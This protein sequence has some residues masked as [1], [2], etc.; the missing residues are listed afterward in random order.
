MGGIDAHQHFWRYSEKEYAW[1]DSRMAVLR[2]DFLPLDLRAVQEPLGF[3]GSVAV[4]ARQS[5][6]ETRWLL[7]LA[8]E[9]P[10]ILGVVG[11]VDL[12]S[13]SV[14]SQIAE[15]SADPKFKGLRHALQSE[16]DDA[17]MLRPEFLR[18]LETVEKA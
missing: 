14:A 16:A 11:W 7:E 8:R 12:C 5:L 2:R 17:F 13:A 18:G 6:E 10:F 4:Q 9:Y 3:E 1:I 15:F